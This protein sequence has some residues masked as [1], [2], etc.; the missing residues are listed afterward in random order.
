MKG[1]E[2]ANSQCDETTA[3]RVNVITLSYTMTK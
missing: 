1:R 2:N 3:K